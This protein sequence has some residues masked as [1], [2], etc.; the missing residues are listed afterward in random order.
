MNNYE[1]NR[2]RVFDVLGDGIII[3]DAWAPMQQTN[4]MAAPY[5]PEANFF[6]LCG[7]DE[8]GWRLVLDGKTK[9]AML[10]EPKR[11]QL[12]IVFDGSIPVTDVCRISG[13]KQ[14]KS[15]QDWRWDLYSDRLVYGKT[16]SKAHGCQ[17]NK[18]YQEVNE[19]YPDMIDIDTILAPLRS[20]KQK[21]EVDAME[22]AVS[23]TIE[24]FNR[25]KDALASCK[26]EAE[27]QAEFDYIFSRNKAKH[28]YEPIV[29]F[30]KNACTLHYVRNSSTFG[31][32]L[33]LI[34]IGARLNGYAAD[35][36][37]TF[38]VGEVTQRE[39]AVHAAVCAVQKDII[40]IIQPGL[41]L[42]DLSKFTCRRLWDALVELKLAEGEYDQGVV[43]RY[44][45][46]S[47][48]H[49]LGV[50]VHEALGTKELVAG[51]V[52][53]VEPGIYIPEES[54]GVRIEDD[55]LVTKDGYKNLSA[56]LSTNL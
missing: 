40:A 29:A 2:Q 28:A 43:E 19:H 6:W 51:Q 13:I 54:I 37:R 55:I 21:H 49:G 22:Q 8:P 4:D 3:L 23:V 48:G 11:S 32:G 34:D 17:S 38:A 12:S 9:Q 36:T 52:I 56:K 15:Y 25:A 5:V 30:G 24:A 50:D 44:M 47:I 10:Y 1:K 33:V 20:V 42:D 14:I 26:T 7:I 46:H 27:L 18:T 53:T 39:R 41:K 45:P 31:N 35:V 16:H